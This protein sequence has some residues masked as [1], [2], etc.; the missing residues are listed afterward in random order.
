MPTFTSWFRFK[1]NPLFLLLLALVLAACGGGGTDPVV[2][3]QPCDMIYGAG[4]FQGSSVKPKVNEVCGVSG[5]GLWADTKGALF[6]ARFGHTATLLPNGKVLVT[7]G[8]D[9]K[10]ALNTS[11]L[12]N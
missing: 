3:I 11:E 5:N 10:N 8:F 1:N 6:D 4:T 2:A 7:G 9:I 12:Y